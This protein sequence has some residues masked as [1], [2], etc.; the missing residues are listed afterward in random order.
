MKLRTSEVFIYYDF[1]LVFSSKGEDGKDFLCI[2]IEETKDNLRYLC[3]PVSPVT[4]MKL[5]H[6]DKDVRSVFEYKE[7]TIL[8]LLLNA[9]SEEPVEATET[10]EDISRF[11]PD[12]G[13]FIGPDNSKAPQSF[14]ISIDSGFDSNLL[15]N[16]LNYADDSAKVGYRTFDGDCIENIETGDY[17]W[18]MMAV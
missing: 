8:N 14:T 4:L 6:N 17:K 18:Q 5:Q 16:L 10:E 15:K 12:E 9:E 7:G 11:L 13:L 1:P 2:F 3:A